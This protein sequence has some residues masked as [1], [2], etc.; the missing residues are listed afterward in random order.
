[1]KLAHQQ[2]EFKL[3]NEEENSASLAEEVD[4]LESK[5]QELSNQLSQ[6]GEEKETAEKRHEA[7]MRHHCH[8]LFKANESCDNSS[9]RI[10]EL[11]TQVDKA[12]TVI[13]ELTSSLDKVKQEETRIKTELVEVRA[14][15]A[16]KTVELKE[17]QDR[18]L[19]DEK[20]IEV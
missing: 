10:D 6:I 15:L 7:E 11:G 20:T 5:H 12:E 9:R 8:L 13:K 2:V 14:Q 16:T 17:S 3:A 1:M 18:I 19:N 4:S